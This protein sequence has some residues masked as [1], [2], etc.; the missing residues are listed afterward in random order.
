MSI[1]NSLK[2]LLNKRIINHRHIVVFGVLCLFIA[3]IHGQQI[4]PK[5]LRKEIMQNQMPAKPVKKV[6]RQRSIQ[7][8]Q[9]PLVPM[10]NP[11]SNKRATI[12][13]LEHNETIT[14]DDLLNPNVQVLKGNVRFRH[15][16]VLM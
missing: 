14:Y 2:Y 3:V 11:L 10:V 5:Q 6:S 8:A 9:K 7:Q 13:Y 12:I 16:N 15:D 1:K 4:R